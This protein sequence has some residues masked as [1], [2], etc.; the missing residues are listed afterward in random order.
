[1]LRGGAI[2]REGGVDSPIMGPVCVV[3]DDDAV[4]TSLERLL[5][6]SGY[7][8]ETFASAEEFLRDADLA[9]ARCVVVDLRMPGASG[10]DLQEQLAG[11]ASDV[12]IVFLTGHA[13]VASGVHAM[14]EGAADFLEKP[15]DPAALLAAVERA[16]RLGERARQERATRERVAQRFAALTPREREVLR[17]LLTGRSNKQI[18]SALGIVERTVKVHRAGIMRKTGAGSLAELVRLSGILGLT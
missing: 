9:A 15:V 4:R 1:M 5:G 14:K 6:T 11:R 2:G 17:E 18:A 12:P 7:E 10:L 13:D 16:S 8:V 3:D